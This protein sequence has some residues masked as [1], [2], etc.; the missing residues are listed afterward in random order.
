M[1]HISPWSGY[2]PTTSV[3]ICTDC[4]GSFKSNS[5]TI[6]AKTVPV[7]QGHLTTWLYNHTCP[8][9]ERVHTRPGKPVKH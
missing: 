8:L 6:T 1:L 3:V 4:T 7:C 9:V 5:H 2:E